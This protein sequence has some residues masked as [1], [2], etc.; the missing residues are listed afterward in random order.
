MAR[1][2]LIWLNFTGCVENGN[3]IHLIPLY[4]GEAE[5]W[6][7]SCQTV[8]GSLGQATGHL[9]ASVCSIYKMEIGIYTGILLEQI[10]LTS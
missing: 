6:G 3:T 10:I 5:H 8:P 2:R 7:R 9:K 1:S 4:T